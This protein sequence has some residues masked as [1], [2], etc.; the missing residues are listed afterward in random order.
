MAG[1]S[2][3]SSTLST[4]ATGST[5]RRSNETIPNFSRPHTP[6][7]QTAPPEPQDLYHPAEVTT[8]T[9]GTTGPDEGEPVRL[10]I[11]PVILA[12]PVVVTEPEP[13][14]ITI[15]TP[16]SIPG[17]AIADLPTASIPGLAIAEPP[18]DMPGI[19]MSDPDPGPGPADIDTPLPPRPSITQRPPTAASTTSST[20]P[21]PPHARRARIAIVDAPPPPTRNGAD[22]KSIRSQIAPSICSPEDEVLSLKVRSLYDSGVGGSDAGSQFSKRVSSIMEEAGKRASRVS[23]NSF[24]GSGD[25]RFAEEEEEAEAEEEQRI[26]EALEAAAIE[27]EEA[28][29][30]KRELE[31]SIHLRAGGAEDWEDLNGSDVDRFVVNPFPFLLLC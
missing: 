18:G 26:K 14:H 28:E 7:S 5:P 16:E 21:P 11:A 10:D 27:E 23:R 25:E 20:S 2:T 31:R 15:L 29:E 22:S 13:E 17:L 9:A 8:S 6:R 19:A 30:E 12:T 3:S 24:V 1:T 4:Q